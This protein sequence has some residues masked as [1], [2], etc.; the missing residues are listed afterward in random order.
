MQKGSYILHGGVGSVFVEPWGTHPDFL[1]Y[2]CWKNDPG[3]TPINAILTS[4]H[5][6]VGVKLSHEMCYMFVLVEKETISLSFAG[7]ALLCSTLLCLLR[8]P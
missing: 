5:R 2:F 3:A 7:S 6:F 8:L 1:G 4:E